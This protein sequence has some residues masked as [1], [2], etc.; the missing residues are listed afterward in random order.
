MENHFNPGRPRPRLREHAISP[1]DLRKPT[2]GN[3]GQD[4]ASELEN[5]MNDSNPP[6]GG[7]RDDAGDKASRDNRANQRNPNNERYW[8]ARGVKDRPDGHSGRPKLKTGQT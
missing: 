4:R 1:G 2:G 7:R 6:S 5:E 8:R 3:D